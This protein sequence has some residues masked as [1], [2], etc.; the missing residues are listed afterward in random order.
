MSLQAVYLCK[1][2]QF[3]KE[4]SFSGKDIKKSGTSCRTITRAMHQTD[5]PR[6]CTFTNL[7]SLGSAHSELYVA[8]SFFLRE[9]HRDLRTVSRRL[10]TYNSAGVLSYLEEV[11]FYFN[12]YERAL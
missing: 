6:A 2:M 3:Q 5:E 7:K 11:L 4:L 9:M 12:F 8:F 1:K 10:L